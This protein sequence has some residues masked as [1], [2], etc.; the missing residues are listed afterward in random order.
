MSFE[1]QSESHSIV[2]P[3]AIPV[4]PT[5]SESA[6]PVGLPALKIS[7]VKPSADELKRAHELRAEAD[8]KKKRST[9]V[10]FK[11][12]LKKKP[13]L[14]AN[15]CSADL[16]EQ[17]ILNFMVLQ[18]R[19]KTATKTLTTTHSVSVRNAKHVEK[20]FWNAFQMD[21]ELGP[22][23]G[24]SWRESNKITKA[25]CPVTGSMDDDKVVW[26][27]PV[28]WESMS[29]ED[30][31]QFKLQTESEAAD[32]DEATVQL[33]A[34][35]TKQQAAVLASGQDLNDQGE[36]QSSEEIE[37]NKRAAI[38]A[39]P[40]KLMRKYQDIKTDCVMLL[41]KARPDR[42]KSK[43]AD[44]LC[45]DLE[46][47]LDTLGRVLNVLDGAVFKTP[48][49]KELK[50]TVEDMAYVDKSSADCK[51]WGENFG[52]VIGNANKKRKRK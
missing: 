2:H 14:V 20:H 49:D 45:T 48:K 28:L 46:A 26:A 34:G 21:R 37:K 41:S 44:M 36:A 15:G 12:Y 40:D 4:V 8:N 29:E 10:G 30:W 35:V 17:L 27:V 31:K 38:A 43:F 39:E 13:D 51:Q 11:E 47:T 9:D 24:K 52:Y 3:Q 22:S 42:T 16:K 23:V 6:M 33:L 32:G 5:A 1:S 7:D 50:K 25:P 19:S 18:L